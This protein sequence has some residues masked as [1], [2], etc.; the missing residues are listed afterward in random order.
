M[1]V[2]LLEQVSNLGKPGE[3]VRVKNG[4]ARNFLLPRKKALRATTS[5]VAVF[6]AK[7]A[8]IEA[9]NEAKKG[10]AED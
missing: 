5:N 7:R 6:E 10:R 2:I 1:Q 9:L 4:Y 3:V 8:E